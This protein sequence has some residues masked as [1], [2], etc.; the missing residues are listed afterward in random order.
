MNRQEVDEIRHRH[1]PLK[2]RNNQFCYWCNTEWPCDAA[3][4]V[5]EV[6]MLTDDLITC[7]VESFLKDHPE[8]REQVEKDLG[9][10]NR[11]V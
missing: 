4:L 10:K 9:G 7:E 5:S 1:F 11:K 8:K 3:R 2:S 6:D